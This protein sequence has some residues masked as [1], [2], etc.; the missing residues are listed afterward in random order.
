MPDPAAL[1][2]HVVPSTPDADLLRRFAADRDP[3]AF[4]ELVRRHGPAVYRVCRRLLG[5]AAADDAF[6]ATFLVLVTRPDSVRKAGSVGSWL[7]GVAGRVARQMRKRERRFAAS[8]R[9]QSAECVQ[10]RPTDVGRSPEWAEQFRVLDEELTRL[11]DRLRGPVVVCLLEG[12]TQEQAVA[13]LGGSAR[14][15][16]RRLDEA[17]RLLRRRLERRGVVPAVAAGLAAGVG[18]ATATVP[19]DLPARTAATV[20][21][22]L[23]G[24]A[25]ASAPPAVIAK[26]VAMGTLARK[27]KLLMVTAAVGLTAL[28]VGLAG[29]DPKPAPPPSSG[30]DILAPVPAGPRPQPAAPRPAPAIEVGPVLR[31]LAM[32]AGYQ[33]DQ[34]HARWVGVPQPATPGLPSLWTGALRNLAFRVVRKGEPVMPPPAESVTVVYTRGEQ[35]GSSDGSALKFLDGR[36]VQAW[37]SLAGPL[38]EVLENDLPREMTH[39]VLASHFGKPFPRWAADGAA[40]TAE[41]SHKQAEYDRACREMLEQGSAVRLSVLFKMTDAPKGQAHSYAQGHSVTRYLLGR[42]GMLTAPALR[43]ISHLAELFRNPAHPHAA[44]LAFAQL[45]AEGDWDKAVKAVY[46]FDDVAALEKAWIGWMSSPE[47]RLARGEQPPR[48]KVVPPKALE[49]PNIPPVKLSGAE[50]E[51][52]GRIVIEGN[53]VTPDRVILDQ[54]PLVPGQVLEYPKLEEARKNLVRL[55]VFDHEDPPTVEAVPGDA[56][57]GF[58]DIRV[59]VKEA[60]RKG[61]R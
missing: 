13:E 12:R 47:S 24:G 16:R 6:Q 10:P 27:V 36:L 55:G 44:F 18:E 17:K 5:P 11:P 15:L 50:P 26:G 51:R 29:D 53:T 14:T 46:G 42:R 54:I 33:R 40:L 58:R 34:I 35:P 49:S 30:V 59:R 9:R 48:P 37:V 3:D 1:L 19:A 23:A 7:V 28:G 60:P 52:V 39:V 41:S 32:E 21:D 57:G 38:D 20:F 4:A 31:A 43:D 2:R 45:G 22:F 25:A 8:G 61:R 56:D